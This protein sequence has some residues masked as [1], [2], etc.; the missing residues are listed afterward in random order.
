MITLKAAV[1]ILT[2]AGAFVFAF[3]E[4]KLK[5]ELSD[6]ALGQRG[7]VADYRSSNNLSERIS[8]ERILESLPLQ[9]RRRLRLIILT[10]FVFVAAFLIAVVVLQR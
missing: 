4:L 2:L 8:R 10:K 5:R 9:T 1:Y 7:N 6:E 3:W